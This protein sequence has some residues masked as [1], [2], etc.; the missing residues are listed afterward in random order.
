MYHKKEAISGKGWLFFSCKELNL[1][2]FDL[3]N[4]KF[5][6]LPFFKNRQHCQTD[7]LSNMPGKM[8]L[9]DSPSKAHCRYFPPLK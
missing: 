8:A 9:S 7:S 5:L 6:K 4:K 3:V 1:L 2:S